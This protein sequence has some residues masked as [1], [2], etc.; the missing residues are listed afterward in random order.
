[1]RFIDYHHGGQWGGRNNGER[2]MDKLSMKAWSGPL[3]EV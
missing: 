2:C 3:W 1:M